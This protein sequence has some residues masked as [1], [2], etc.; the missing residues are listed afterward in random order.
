MI[1]VNWEGGLG[2][3][4]TGTKLRDSSELV[5]QLNVATQ[6]K[7]NSVERSKEKKTVEH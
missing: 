5:C 7:S 1:A 4:W 6:E 2:E 3:S